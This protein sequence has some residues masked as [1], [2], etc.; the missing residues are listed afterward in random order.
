MK[1]FNK[2]LFCFW[3]SCCSVLTGC[4]QPAPSCSYKGG[5]VDFLPAI[6]C[7]SD[8][9]AVQNKPLSQ[10]YGD[11][12]SIKIV[13]D[14]NAA[15][16]YFL[17][18]Y[19]YSYHFDF[20][21]AYL[22]TYK[23]LSVFNDIEYKD[24]PQRKYVLANLNH[25]DASDIYTLELFADDHCPSNLVLDLFN[26]VKKTTYFG[27]KIRL[28]NS[29]EQSQRIIDETKGLIPFISVDE[30]YG[31][32]IFQ[33]MIIAGRYG[34]LRKVDQA[35]FDTFPFQK[36]DIIVTNFLPNNFPYCQGIITA[37]FQTPLCH[38]NILSHNRITPNCA[39][40]FAMT[41]QL[42]NTYLNQLVYYE[43]TNDTF[44]IHPAD[45]KEAELYWANQERK[46]TQKLACNINVKTL[47]DIKDI[48]INSVSLVGG[49]AAN[50]GELAK[51]K[52][53]DNTSIPMPEAAFAIPFYFYH[54]HIIANGLQP[55]IDHILLNPS[56]INSR[57]LLEKELKKIQDTIKHA[58]LDPIL[59]AMV[60]TRLQSNGSFTEYRFRSSTNAEDIVGFNGAGLYESKT[61]SLVNPQKTVAEAI[62]KVWASLW[63]IRA[64]E[65]REVVGID[66][67]TIAMGI[68]VHRAFGEEE[69]NGVAITKDLYRMSYPSFTINVQKGETSVVVPEDSSVCDQLLIKF[70]D[71]FNSTNN[72]AIE[73][74][75]HSSL[76]HF[77]P[78]MTRAEIERLA[79]YLQAIK[80][81]FYNQLGMAA[82]DI[83]YDDFA[84]DVEFKLDKN[85]RKIYIKQARTY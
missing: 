63:D 31:K 26:H 4:T 70:S 6:N 28:L 30:I 48:G 83:A 59:L 3:V 62:K 49:K 21:Y 72:I 8:F 80:R 14:I 33:P 51:I 76:N 47:V 16:V 15:K 52:L 53:P 71:E 68:L 13:Y 38:V 55:L 75:S 73:Y 35:I 82:N 10:N 24:S 19:N 34:Y 46:R 64:F 41:D 25:Y 74:I 2:V 57:L 43:V 18:S 32:Q 39:Y 37:T 12:Q 56:I 20:C 79:Y 29:T 67:Q 7:S 45:L 50:F 11:I 65:E 5:W 17:N 84:M 81:H 42:I 69:A 22:K 40:K 66:Q 27:D 9:L 36:H 85:T 61:G 60:Q 54:Q 23:D 1:S 77:Q 44:I 78:V 58:P